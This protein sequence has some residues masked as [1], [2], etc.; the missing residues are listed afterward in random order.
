MANRLKE[1]NREV[2]A[3]IARKLARGIKRQNPGWTLQQINDAAFKQADLQ[4]K[5]GEVR[6]S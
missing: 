2:R 3:E 4:I 6:A 1:Q 5:R